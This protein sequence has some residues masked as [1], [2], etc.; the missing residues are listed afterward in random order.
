MRY[1]EMSYW[2]EIVIT[3]ELN[4]NIMDKYRIDLRVNDKEHI[5]RKTLY[6]EK[7]YSDKRKCMILND[8]KNWFYLNAVSDS[9]SKVDP[10]GYFNLCEKGIKNAIRIHNWKNIDQIKEDRKR[11]VESIDKHIEYIDSGKQYKE[12]EQH[13]ER[14]DKIINLYDKVVKQMEDIAKENNNVEYSFGLF[15]FKKDEKYEYIKFIK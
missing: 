6:I 5:Q 10:K 9:N 3:D 11:W 7:R 1:S 2:C 8:I 14:C 13:N 15:R 12:A 4:K